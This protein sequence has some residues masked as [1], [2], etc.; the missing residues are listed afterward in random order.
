MTVSVSEISV[1][2]PSIREIEI[3]SDQA[4]SIGADVLIGYPNTL[5]D[6]KKYTKCGFALTEGEGEFIMMLSKRTYDRR[7]NKDLNEMFQVGV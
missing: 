2:N 7:I 1:T 3:A 5:E 4:F 6:I